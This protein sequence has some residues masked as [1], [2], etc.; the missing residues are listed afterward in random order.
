[1]EGGVARQECHTPPG[2]SNPSTLV[3][4]AVST[5]AGIY[6]GSATRIE[7]PELQMLLGR[8]FQRDSGELVTFSLTPEILKQVEYLII[9]VTS[10]V[11]QPE[12]QQ[13]RY[14]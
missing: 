2:S 4:W 7:L 1:V 12:K 9:Q 8:S 10:A 14:S 5:I 6:R 13:Y 3:N 11:K